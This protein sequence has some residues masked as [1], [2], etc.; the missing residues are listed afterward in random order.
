MTKTI[1][2]LLSVLTAVFHYT[3]KCWMLWFMSQC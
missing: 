2:K 1:N 3:S